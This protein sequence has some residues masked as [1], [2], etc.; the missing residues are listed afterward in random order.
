MLLGSG[1]TE[2]E[3][4]ERTQFYK[5]ITFFLPKQFLT[6]LAVRKIGVGSQTS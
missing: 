6:L 1:K 2:M 4:S 5:F 3:M